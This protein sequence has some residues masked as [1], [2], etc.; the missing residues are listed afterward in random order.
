MNKFD[1]II[2]ERLYERPCWAKTFYRLKTRLTALVAAGYVE[3]ISPPGSINTA[4][5]MLQ[6]TDKGIARIER[7]WRVRQRKTDLVELAERMAD[8]DEPP[9]CAASK[10][11]LSKA[12]AQ[13]AFDDMVLE[14][15]AQAA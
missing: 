10:I 13:R 12:R 3:R 4:Q 1:I 9:E 15:G 7:H 11:G 8:H 2:F 5:N 14:L 6:L